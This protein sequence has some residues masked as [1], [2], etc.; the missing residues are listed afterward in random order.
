[1]PNS[2]EYVKRGESKLITTIGRIY[3]LHHSSICGG[4]GYT[5]VD[6]DI[7]IRR[8]LFFRKKIGILQTMV[9]RKI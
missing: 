1:M 4:R 5:E 9:K 8:A 3:S 2:E 7:S 6:P